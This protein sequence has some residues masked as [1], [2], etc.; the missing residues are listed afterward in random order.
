M[1]TLA[2]QL[3]FDFDGV[4]AYTERIKQIAAKRLFHKDV[5]INELFIDAVTSGKSPI[6]PAEY[7]QILTEL[8]S[9]EDWYDFLDPVQGAIESIR[10]LVE[11]GHD[12]RIVSGRDGKALNLAEKWALKKGIDVPFYGVGYRASK[13]DA[14]DGCVL[15]VDDDLHY[16]E[17]LVDSIE[18][19]YL[20]SWPY[21]AG[22]STG[23][24]ATRIHGW[25]EI[26]Q[27]IEEIHTSH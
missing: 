17:P 5:S 9:N 15:F 20:F 23:K 25:T 24:I 7:A 11:A 13:K 19:R 2:M 14:L 10:S 27:K 3:G 12:V 6:T 21:N 4:T 18:Y 1:Y 22:Q 16:L 8:W 26:M